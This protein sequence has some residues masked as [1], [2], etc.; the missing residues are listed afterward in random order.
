MTSAATIFLISPASL[1]G[2][3][4][5]LLFNPE[6]RFELARRLRSS[7]GAPLGEVFTFVSGLYFRGK[8]A[9]AQRFGRAEAKPA[10]YVMTAGGG[11][12]QLGEPV[13]L[14]RL[15]GWQKVSVSE[16][17]PHFTAPL[18]RQVCELSDQ[19]GPGARFVLLGSLASHKY[20]IPLSEAVGEA[21]HFPPR[22]AGLGDMSRGSLLLRCVAQNEEL[23]YAPVKL[24]SAA[25]GNGRR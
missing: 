21:L 25:T 14:A 17:N 9:Y 5:K 7:E 10:A 2:K 4:G 24:A 18:I 20:V 22:L 6:A 13:T 19:V 11:L 12:W 23:E 15:E 3:R 16:H 8:M 1:S